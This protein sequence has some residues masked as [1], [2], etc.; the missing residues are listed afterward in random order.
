MMTQVRRNHV[1]FTTAL[2]LEDS[3]K[4]KC[5][6]W[7]RSKRKEILK[8]KV[9]TQMTTMTGMKRTRRSMDS[10]S[11][12]KLQ[13]TIVKWQ[14]TKTMRLNF[15]FKFLKNALRAF[16]PY[17]TCYQVLFLP[18]KNCP[19]F[20]M[21]AR[22]RL[23]KWSRWSLNS[24]WPSKRF[25]TWSKGLLQI[26]KRFKTWSKDLSQIG[27]EWQGLMQQSKTWHR[28]MKQWRRRWRLWKRWSEEEWRLKKIR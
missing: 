8:N 5:K 28:G 1:V 7:K 27:S 12:L 9:R 23:Q 6:A 24:R 3:F 16:C 22:S 26:G 17:R 11:N 25:K 15:W 14:P 19:S 18:M 10:L 4:S 20:S 2:K 21:K 13:L